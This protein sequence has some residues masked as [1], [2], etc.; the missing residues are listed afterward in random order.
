MITYLCILCT[1]IS[2][3]FVV[4]FVRRELANTQVLR[5]L[6]AQEVRDHKQAE[7]EKLL[8]E[9][10][11]VIKAY[12]ESARID[13]SESN[14][15]KHDMGSIAETISTRVDLKSKELVQEIKEVPQ[16]VADVLKSSDSNDASTLRIPRG[17]GEANG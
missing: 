15:A 5:Y 12:R 6:K 16:K 10:L 3:L 8:W 7:R 9:I 2:I 1:V 14:L 13:R 17:L 11:E 4:H